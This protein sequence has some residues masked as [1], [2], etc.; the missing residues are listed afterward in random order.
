MVYF[1][2]KNPNLGKFLTALDWKMLI[3]FMAIWNILW[4]FWV[5]YDHLVN[6]V[7]LRYISSGFGIMHQEKSGNPVVNRFSKFLSRPDLL[8][9]G[10][11]KKNLKS[12]SNPFRDCQIFLGPNLPKR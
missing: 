2:T 11:N 4:T 12:A 8:K 1:Q 10:N 5:F 9:Q 3:N 7:F 6:F